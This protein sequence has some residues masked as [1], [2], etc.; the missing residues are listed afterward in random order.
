ADDEATKILKMV[1]DKG[2]LIINEAVRVGEAKA[3]K[4]LAQAQQEASEIVAKAREQ[5]QSNESFRAPQNREH[6]DQTA[7]EAANVVI[8]SQFRTMMAQALAAGLDTVMEATKKADTEATSIIVKAKETGIQI[9]EEAKRKRED[10]ARKIVSQAEETGRQIIE[11][12]KRKADDEGNKIVTQALQTG[13]QIIVEAA[14][15]ADTEVETTK[16]ISHGK[17]PGHRIEEAKAAAVNGLLND[18]KYSDVKHKVL[19]LTKDKKDTVLAEDRE[20]KE[21]V[22]SLFKAPPMAGEGKSAAAVPASQPTKAVLKST[23]DDSGS[24]VLHALLDCFSLWRKPGE[25][26]YHIPIK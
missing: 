20:L 14:R 17:L 6:I 2:K 21:L 13:L 23:K 7:S 10:E 26:S 15:I 11:E 8:E 25:A 1:E 9:I 22:G 16:R 5:A 19:H 12:A 24:S 4:M 18:A 3:A